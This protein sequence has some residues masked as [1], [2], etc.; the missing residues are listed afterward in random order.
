MCCRRSVSK[1]RV[2]LLL[3]PGSPSPDPMAIFD[4]RPRSKFSA[5][6]STLLRAAHA[7]RSPFA[8][9]S[10]QCAP[11]ATILCLAPSQRAATF[12]C[13]HAHH[14]HQHHASSMSSMH[15]VSH[16]HASVTCAAAAAPGA[17]SAT[18][19]R[20]LVP[21]A[22][23]TEEMEAIIVIDVLRR[24]GAEVVVAS[25]EPQLEVRRRSQR[26]LDPFTDETY[27]AD[28]RVRAPHRSRARAASRWWP[29]SSSTPPPSRAS[30][31]SRSRCVHT[32]PTCALPR[33]LNWEAHED[34]EPRERRT[35]GCAR[36]RVGC[37]EPSACGTRR[38]WRRCSGRRGSSA[39]PTPP[40]APRRPCSWRQRGSSA[41]GSGPPRTRPFPAS[42]GTRGALG[43]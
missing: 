21:I 1:R 13:Q 29:T 41:R 22:N 36:R 6:M 42:S 37:R 8:A 14:Q 39:S 23:G 28:R 9:A 43:V 12:P 16:G 11:R 31:S 26:R 32:A 40:S 35:W 18:T 7:A 33:A 38:P 27:T 3:P 10:R 25:V 17:A 4:P 5:R 20:V 30:T 24:A 19:K 34:G 2:P 15:H